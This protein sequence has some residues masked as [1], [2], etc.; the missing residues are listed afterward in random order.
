[1]L[2]G[3]H[4][5]FPDMPLVR[6]ALE[7]TPGRCSASRLLV[8]TAAGG[9]WRSLWSRYAVLAFGLYPLQ[10][11]H[12]R[13]SSLRTLVRLA[14]A[15]NDLL[16]F[17]QGTHARPG[18]ERAGDTRVHFRAGVAHIA[19]ALRC[20]V[21][22]FRVAGTERMMPPFPEEF[23]G[24]VIAGVPVAFKRGPLAIAFGQPLVLGPDEEPAAFASRL[25]AICYD[26]TRAAEQALATS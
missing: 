25:Q 14:Q 22:P 16:I 4:H 3:T 2:A 24:P 17:P 11:E 19:A 1:V 10:R 7:L 6:H 13:E 26:L 9:A 18:E 5:S 8:A 12:D 23:R 15:G 21:V 20:P